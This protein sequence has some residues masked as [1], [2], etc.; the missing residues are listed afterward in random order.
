MLPLSCLSFSLTHL[1]IP[2]MLL[3][4]SQMATCSGKFSLS[5]LVRLKLHFSVFFKHLHF[6]VSIEDPESR[7][8][9][10]CIYLPQKRRLNREHTLPLFDFLASSTALRPNKTAVVHRGELTELYIWNNRAD[11]HRA[12]P[13][14]EGSGYILLGIVFLWTF[15]ILEPCL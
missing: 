15:S 10:Q 14:A 11:L 5:P 1:P 8:K 12:A 13:A 9:F 2:M 3:R 4:G 7:Y 6:S